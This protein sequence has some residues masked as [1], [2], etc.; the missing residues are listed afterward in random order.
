MC[1]L[2]LKFV[3]LPV[4]EIMGVLKKSGQSLDTSTL[5]F[6]ADGQTDGRHAISIPRYALVHRAVKTSLYIICVKDH[7][8]RIACHWCMLLIRVQLYSFKNFGVIKKCT[9]TLDVILPEQETEV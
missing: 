1:V 8:Y 6:L 7:K 5:Y 4:P 9:I 3:A 2:N